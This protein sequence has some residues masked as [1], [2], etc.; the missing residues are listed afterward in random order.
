MGG[1]KLWG[2]IFVGLQLEYVV[3]SSLY[4][5]LPMNMRCFFELSMV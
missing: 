5:K 4:A 1:V 3:E 2:N